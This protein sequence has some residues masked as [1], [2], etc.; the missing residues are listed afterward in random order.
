MGNQFA[1]G[2]IAISICDRCGFQYLLKELKYEVVKQK[3]TG[4]L[5]CQSCYNPDHPQLMLGTFPVYDPQALRNPRMD[6]SYAISGP[7]ANGNLGEGSRNIYWGW[8]PVGG[9]DASID[10]TPNPLAA[11]GLI[12]TITVVT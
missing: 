2:K 11:K 3:R 7:L 1:S 9:G 6:T 5:V 12:G 10:N 8:N 4:L